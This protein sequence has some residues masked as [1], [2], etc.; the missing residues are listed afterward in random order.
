[1]KTI[2]ALTICQ[3]WAWAVMGP[4][5]FENRDWYTDYQGPLVIHAGKSTSWMHEGVA[6]LR[7]LGIEPPR[8]L[9]FGAIIGVVDQVDCIRPSEAKRADGT[10]DPFAMLD[11]AWCHQYANPRRLATPIP[12]KGQQGFFRVPAELVKSIV[13][14]AALPDAR[15]G[16]T[17]EERL[18]RA[19]KATGGRV[20]RVEQPELW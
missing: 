3:P 15:P 12:Y 16:E 5:R 9:A 7:S 6:F 20:G 8:D 18:D 11:K 13:D 17:K 2:R 10:P 1:M 19:V 4:K 14:Y